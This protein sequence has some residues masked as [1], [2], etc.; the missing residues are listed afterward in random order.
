MFP[1]TA[2]ALRQD[3]MDRTPDEMF[4]IVSSVPHY[5]SLLMTLDGHLDKAVRQSIAK[6]FLEVPLVPPKD[7]A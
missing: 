3:M 5:F 2:E 6:V 4:H 1:A 7:I